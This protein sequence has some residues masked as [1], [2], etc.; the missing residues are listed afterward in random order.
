M[1]ASGIRVAARYEGGASSSLAKSCP[2]MR[3]A[4]LPWLKLTM[5]RSLRSSISST[6]PLMPPIAWSITA[7]PTWELGKQLLSL[8]LQLSLSLSPPVPQRS[9]LIALAIKRRFGNFVEALVRDL[10]ELRQSDF[11]PRLFALAHVIVSVR[12]SRPQKFFDHRWRYPAAGH[13]GGWP[14][15][16]DLRVLAPEDFQ[17]FDKI[18]AVPILAL[19]LKYR[20]TRL[21]Q[22]LRTRTHSPYKSWA[23]GGNGFLG[24]ESPIRLST[25]STTEISKP[26]SASAQYRISRVS[27]SSEAFLPASNAMKRSAMLPM[28]AGVHVG[29]REHVATNGYGLD[30]ARR[31][32]GCADG[33]G[34]AFRHDQPP[35]VSNARLA[36]LEL[37]GSDRRDAGRMKPQVA[38]AV[39]PSAISP[40]IALRNSLTM[41]PPPF[42]PVARVVRRM[43][44]AN[45]AA[46][47]ICPSSASVYF[48]RHASISPL[49]DAIGAGAGRSR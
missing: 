18:E 48:L 44:S 38:P 36:Q 25:Y 27:S 5:T 22:S 32:I 47:W 43:L 34:S 9:N 7:A 39:S 26:M 19:D 1:H 10:L 13:N 42:G 11:G 41:L 2:Q 15:R 30:G 23:V 4:C 21:R 24:V 37:A 40:S 8:S 20:C 46:A 49:D 35:N 31:E 17:L 6:I 33:H 16:I 3:N 12:D 14:E 29:S 28:I 45:K